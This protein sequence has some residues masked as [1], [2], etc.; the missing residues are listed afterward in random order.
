MTSDVWWVLVAPLIIATSSGILALVADAWSKRL[1]A[2]SFSLVGLVGA[3][4]ASVWLSLDVAGQLIADVML[5]DRGL[6]GV[7][8][9]AFALSALSLAAGTEFV[10]SHPSGGGV[11]GLVS[12][13]AAGSA[14]LASSI[15]LLF[16]LLLLETIAIAGYALIAAVRTPAAGE[17]ALKYVVQGAV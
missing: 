9:A 5:V 2:L 12:F 17:A 15:D 11:A 7:W 6:Y 8:A 3:A 14:A 16:T 4:A 1:W 13:T 10:R